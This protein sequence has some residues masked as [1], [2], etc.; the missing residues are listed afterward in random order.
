MK[1]IG[2]RELANLPDMDA[3]LA[4][5]VE[6]CVAQTRQ[7]A[8]RQETFFRGQLGDWPRLDPSAST[9]CELVTQLARHP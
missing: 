2:V 6:R 5:A 7:Y 9:L 3:G 8:K 1:A 4:A